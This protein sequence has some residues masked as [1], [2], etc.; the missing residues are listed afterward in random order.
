MRI[1]FLSQYFWPEQFIF[2]DLM[3]HLA[4][5]GH[6]VTVLTGK[7]NYPGGRVFDGYT[8]SG[9]QREAF[10][11]GIEIHRV[12]LRARRGTG[13][14]NLLA[15][16]LSFVWQ[17]LRH[18][19][20]CL[21]GKEFDAIFVFASPITAA[22]PALP[23]GGSKRAHVA[24]WVQDLWPESLE[25]TGYIRNRW[26]LG[27]VGL[28]VRAIYALADTILVQSPGFIPLVSR[29]AR[30]DR[31]LYYP[32]SIDLETTRESPDGD[33]LPAAL[34][35]V[36]EQNFCVVFAGNLGR[37]QSVETIIQAAELLRDLDDCKIV[38]VGTGSMLDW[39]QSRVAALGLVNVVL[40]GRFPGSRMPGIFRKA[41]VLLVTLKRD[42]AL[43]STIPSKIQAYLAAG[44]PII[45]GMDGEGA[46]IVAEA[47]AGLA[48][49]AE[50]ADGLA[51]CIRAMHAKS[52]GERAQMGESGHRYFLQHFEMGG[53]ARRLVELL[54]QRMAGG[55]T[56]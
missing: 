29:Y 13:A 7:P 40:P 21:R 17:G 46:R 43:S 16:H 42:P 44:R 26:L 11:E 4:R 2:N 52:P 22:I 56:R 24:L 54:E 8:E 9:V 53:Q 23:L 15:N 30:P 51:R 50:D 10:Q 34:D 12:P 45:A 31:I 3:R 41:A 28:M 25:A 35:D 1:L 27:I 32:N 19:G 18:A 33:P 38:L 49:A 39:I 36:L 47:G 14:W 55:R 48:C 6:A 5:Q 37:A 20:A